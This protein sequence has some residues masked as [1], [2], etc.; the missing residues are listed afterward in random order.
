MHASRLIAVFVV[1]GLVAAG[2]AGE[3]VPTKRRIPLVA[4]TVYTNASAYP[5][6]DEEHIATL[7]ALDATTATFIVEFRTLGKPAESRVASRS[8]RRQDFANSH[9]INHIFQTGDPDQFPAS[10]FMH[11]SAT[12][13]RELKESGQTPMVLGTIKDFDGMGTASLFSFVQSG[14]KYFRGTLK[15][16]GTGTIP[17][18]VLVNGERVMLPA[19]ETAGRFEV[20]GDSLDARFWWLD[21]PDNALLLR[22]T[23]G[24][25]SG[26][27]VRI[28]LPTQV[29]N[30]ELLERQ[31]EAGD[32]R[33]ALSGLYFDT[34]SARLLPQSRAT[35]DAVA[36][37]L[38]DRPTWNLTIEGH[39]DSVGK[40]AY[41]LDLSNRRAAAVRAALTSEFG[42]AGTRLK[43][44][45]F[46]LTRPIASN[47]T[48]DGR[49]T[50]R[51]VELVRACP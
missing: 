1:L 33:A 20:G 14:R 12:A 50:N 51:R 8:V 13:L 24:K 35:L 2:A 48:L 16:V 40:P 46:G 38:R 49:A 7:A 9:R 5:S 44:A 19:I 30:S 34:A 27:I 42:I 15:R 47:A 10:T 23:Q 39:T 32:C 36:K 31:L 45:G 17:I 21:D 22:S 28:D 25:N 26:Q 41:N 37:L 4:G 43:A 3:G 11:L 29:P 6:G 18:P